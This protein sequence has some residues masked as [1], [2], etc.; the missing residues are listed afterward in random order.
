M[1]KNTILLKMFCILLFTMFQINLNAQLN[2]VKYNYKGNL[3]TY[4][5]LSRDSATHISVTGPGKLKITTHARFTSESPDSLSYTVVYYIDNTDVKLFNAKKVIRAGKDVFIQSIDDMPSTPKKYII[6]VEPGVHD[7]NFLMLNISPQ[8]DLRY[9]FV[10]DSVV[11]W[12]DKFSLTDTSEINIRID[13]SSTK[14]Y[15]RFSADNPQ[16]FKVKG[17]TTLRVLTR[18]EY[19]YSMQGFISYL[20]SVKRNDTIADT[21]KL[22]GKPS[23]EAQYTNDKKLI[24]GTLEEFFL[25]VPAGDN[26][27]EFTLLDKKLTALIRVSKGSKVLKKEDKS[28]SL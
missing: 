5:A 22:E 20:V 13:K 17:P 9:K 28:D 3:Y 4:Y 16:K 14:P 15:Y 12:K 1:R 10:P 2:R 11:E 21:Y 7:Y 23:Q 18:L 27:Y 6:K 8:V 25:D 24:P 19:N 26:Y